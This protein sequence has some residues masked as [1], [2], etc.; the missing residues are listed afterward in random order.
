MDVSLHSD[1]SAIQLVMRPPNNDPSSFV[2][3]LAQLGFTVP[4]KSVRVL[5]QGDPKLSKADIRVEDPSFAKR[6]CQK[7]RS[8][9][10]SESGTPQATAQ[11]IPTVMP[12]ASNSCRMDRKKVYVSWD[13]PMRSVHLVFDESRTKQRV[14]RGFQTGEYKILDQLVQAR[15]TSTP[16]KYRL[17]LDNVLAAATKRD[18]CESLPDGTPL[19]DIT[20][21]EATY[22]DVDLVIALVKS[23]FMEFGELQH[24][25]DPVPSDTSARA[26][27]KAYFLDEEDARR[28][29][30]ALDESP[31]SICENVRLRAHIE[32]SVKWKVSNRIYDAVYHQ[33][34]AE[35]KHW[36]SQSLT[37]IPYPASN[38]HRVLELHGGD[39]ERVINARDRLKQIL[40]GEIAKHNGKDI[41]TP[42][43]G[44]SGKSSRKI[45]DLEQ[46]LKIAIDRNVRL[47]HL[48]VYGE[49]EK[50]QEAIS[51][52]LELIEEDSLN[53][54]MI[55]L[56]EG[57]VK[58][59]RQGGFQ[60]LSRR[61]GKSVVAF[62]IRTSPKR[63]LA[64]GSEKD[65]NVARDMVAES[66]RE[67]GKTRRS[68]LRDQDC[69]VC[70]DDL[71]DPVYTQCSH[72]YCRECFKGLCSSLAGGNGEFRICC[73]G[74]GGKCKRVLELEVLQENLSSTN[75]EE[76]LE[77][78]VDSYI[79]RHPGTFHWCPT[80]DCRQVYRTSRKE[81][82]FNCPACL[83]SVCTACHAI[84]HEGMTCD[85]L[86]DHKTGGYKA[87]EEAKAE[88]DIRPCLKCGSLIQKSDG[89]NHMTCGGCGTHICWVCMKTF[90]T[91]GACYD[92]M[93]SKHGGIGLNIPNVD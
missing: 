86:E 85:E 27:A 52:L 16:S 87:L 36:G 71:E 8:R 35:R 80:P 74:D 29:A 46:R 3:F 58:W 75:L 47:S 61:L 44:V 79:R 62:D 6:L 24:W 14:Q 7:L 45:Q 84:S 5:T 12:R 4:A 76:V 91:S 69:V 13:N 33:T 40:A 2:A 77:A 30:L 39:S 9:N 26:K 43:F 68:A 57:Q 41:W 93:G 51:L 56:N 50:L 54:Q 90:M 72:A 17:I 38:G 1:F 22:D 48:R 11:P 73:E 70:L 19:K 65:F 25:D 64:F 28:A 31:L 81:A 32:Y 10:S 55:P 18:I 66:K 92:H 42:S 15:E 89:C 21:R 37:F 78:S 88:H 82:V 49:P 34:K 60:A 23:S 83:K 63:I 59:A 53:L 67:T 20:L